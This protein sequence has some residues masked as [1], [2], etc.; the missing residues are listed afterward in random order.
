MAAP[1]MFALSTNPDV[2]LIPPTAIAALMVTDAEPPT[3][4]ES[5]A[6]ESETKLHFGMSTVVLPP[7]VRAFFAV[8]SSARTH[9]GPPKV[10]TA[11]PSMMKSLG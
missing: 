7:E 6:L 2:A 5:E 9:A 1:L 10:A 11:R 8:G 4:N 3:D